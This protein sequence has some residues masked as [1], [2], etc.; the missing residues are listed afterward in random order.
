MTTLARI[1]RA[2]LS[3]AVL[4]AVG[5]AALAEEPAALPAGGRG[6]PSRS[7]ELE[8][9]SRHVAALDAIGLTVQAELRA[10]RSRVGA[11]AR[12]G[13][14]ED[15]ERD[16]VACLSDV[17]SRVHV[18]ARAARRVRDDL[19]GAVAAND[20][21]GTVRETTRLVHLR[22]RGARLAREARDCGELGLVIDA[23]GG[24]TVRVVSPALPDA[25]RYPEA[26][27]RGEATFPGARRQP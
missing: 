26:V 22:D 14:G 15:P 10:A 5:G 19:A 24:T 7:A 9:A 27:R 21:A 17:L 6:A 13:P 3:T 16:R 18:T 11:R 8:A 25:A 23:S 4:L 2:A 1:A 20:G 12:G